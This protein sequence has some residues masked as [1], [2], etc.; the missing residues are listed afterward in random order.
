MLGPG[1]QYDTN[2]DRYADVSVSPRQC[3]SNTSLE[4]VKTFW[5]EFGIRDMVP[6]LL[7]YQRKVVLSR[8]D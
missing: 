1:T 7:A 8:I 4:F 2:K 3:S 5:P 6:I